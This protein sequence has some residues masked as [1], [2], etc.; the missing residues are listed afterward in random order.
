MKNAVSAIAAVI[1][2]L[3]PPTYLSTM[4]VI[5]P[6]YMAK[7]KNFPPWTSWYV[8]YENNTNLYKDMPR[9]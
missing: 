3:K 6:R 8:M 1:A 7:L 5:P 2:N 4:N 9:V